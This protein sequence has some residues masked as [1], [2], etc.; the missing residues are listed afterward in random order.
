MSVILSW[1]T[2]LNNKMNALAL[3]K[4]QRSVGLGGISGSMKTVSSKELDPIISLCP[5]ESTAYFAIYYR[6]TI[7]G[8]N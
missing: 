8:K 5:K 4:F 7:Q 6:V 3:R 1:W 2:S